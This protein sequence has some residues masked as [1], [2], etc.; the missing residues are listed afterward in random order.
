MTKQ[1]VVEE[2]FSLY[3]YYMSR[4]YQYKKKWEYEFKNRTKTKHSSEY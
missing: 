4:I 2:L 1:T 3:S